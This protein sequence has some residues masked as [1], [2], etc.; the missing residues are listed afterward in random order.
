[1]GTGPFPS[2]FLDEMGVKLTIGT[3]FGVAT[4]PLLKYSVGVNCYTA[5]NLAKLDILDQCWP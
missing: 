4:G 3:E 1:M 5:I 2:E